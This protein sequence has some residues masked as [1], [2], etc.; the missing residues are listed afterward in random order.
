MKKTML[1]S[2]VALSIMLLGSTPSIV[3]ADTTTT[4]N[5][6]KDKGVVTTNEIA[7][8]YSLNNNR[9]K[10]VKN[11]ALSDGSS[12]IYSKSLSGIDG[13]TYYRVATNEWVKAS[14]LSNINTKSSN[15]SSQQSNNQ[16]VDSAVLDKVVG[17][18]NSKVYHTYGQKNFK[19]STKNVVYFNTEQD[20]INAGFHKSQI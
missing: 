9:L 17:N 1:S 16:T 13:E 7:T 3:N 18:S 8:L 4:G 11:R 5:I 6:S 15:N 19:I 12:W 14:S 2:L 20:A 10:R